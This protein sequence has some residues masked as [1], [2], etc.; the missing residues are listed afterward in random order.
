MLVMSEIGE[1]GTSVTTFMEGV[2]L[3]MLFLN[4]RFIRL[5]DPSFSSRYFF[6]PIIL[7][8]SF[9]FLF[10]RKYCPNDGHIGIIHE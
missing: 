4:R 7:F 6:I 10:C 1:M 9:P 8:D 3:R 2:L 5:L